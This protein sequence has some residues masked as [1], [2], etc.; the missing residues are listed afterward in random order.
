MTVNWT[1]TA[2]QPDMEDFDDSTL[3]ELA[4]MISGD[5]AGMKRRGGWELAPF[6]RRVAGTTF[7]ITTAAHETHGFWISCANVRETTPET[8]SV[9]FYAWPT[10]ASTNNNPASTPL[11]S[12]AS[13]KSWPLKDSASTTATADPALLNTTP[14]NHHGR[15]ASNSRS[16]SPTSSLIPTWPAPS[17][18]VWTKRTLVK[19]TAP[20]PQRSSCSAASSKAC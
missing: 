10:G 20:T 19:N 5:E 2:R 8:S 14:T 18:Y 9:S 6:L 15:S 7:P 17:S 4:A 1:M 16:P 3:E 12:N 11:S 13:K